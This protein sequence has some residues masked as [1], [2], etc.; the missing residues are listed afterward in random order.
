MFLF[1]LGVVLISFQV[2]FFFLG[3]DM[4]ME[5]VLLKLKRSF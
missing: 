3:S 1:T 4:S 5:V 2:I